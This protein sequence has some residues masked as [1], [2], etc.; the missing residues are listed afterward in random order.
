MR[1]YCEGLASILSRISAFPRGKFLFLFSLIILSHINLL[2]PGFTENPDGNIIYPN[3]RSMSSILEYLKSLA[4]FETI[5]FQ[6]VRDFTLF[7]DLWFLDNHGI[8]IG[9]LLNCLVWIIICYNL[10]LILEENVPGI[11]RHWALLLVATLS[12]NPIYSQAINWVIARKHLL[13]V[14]FT[15][16]ATRNFFLYLRG[17]SSEFRIV[18]FYILSLLS[19]PASMLWPVWVTAHLYLTK[20]LDGII[21]RRLLLPL[22]IIMILIVGINWAYYKTSYTFLEIYP[23][24]ATARDPFMMAMSLGQQFIQVIFPYDLAFYN[25]LGTKALVGF[26]LFIIFISFVLYRYRKNPEVL[27][28]VIFSGGHLAVFLS[29]PNIYYDTYVLFPSIGLF[30][31][32]VYMLKNKLP[33]FAYFLPFLL[34]VWVTFTLLNNPLWGNT[35]K[36]FKKSFEHQESCANAI[37]YAT[38]IYL[39]GSVL[40]NSLFD[41]IQTNECMKP[42][43]NESPG[44]MIR[45]LTFES[46]QLYFEDEIDFD[47]RQKRLIELGMKHFYPLS[48]YAAFLAKYDQKEKIENVSAYLNSKFEGTDTKIEFDPI[49]MKIVPEYCKKHQLPECLRYV[50]RWKDK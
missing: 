5:D 32:A 35:T 16:L 15:M 30:F 42:Q 17:R 4:A 41:Y 49:F 6:P 50:E 44:I 43:E 25:Y 10:L 33:K 40:P 29:T 36:F 39:E 37:A 28:W 24:K 45:K 26:I 19:L 11:H 1:K 22:S 27:T 31:I 9:I 13:A 8:V 48:I 23:Q 2:L 12:V 38:G 46:L 20:K 34:G 14:M 7:I 47:Y 18:I 21:I 3:L